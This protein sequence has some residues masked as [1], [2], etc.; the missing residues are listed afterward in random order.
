MSELI[1][2]MTLVRPIR[3][4][5]V[6]EN[7]D[8]STFQKLV[9]F[10][11]EDLNGIRTLIL[12]N[13]EHLFSENT[14]A[15]V[16]THDPDVILNY[17]KASDQALYERYRTKVVRTNHRPRELQPYRTHLATVQQ[18]PTV[19]RNIFAYQGKNLALDETIYALVRSSGEKED[20]KDASLSPTVEELCFAVNCGSV[21]SGFFDMRKFGVFRDVK[22]ES[23]STFR[24][25]V[26]AVRNDDRFIQLSTH[27]AGNGTSQSIWEVDHNFHQS[28]QDKSTIIIGAGDDLRSL[29]YFW[30]E[31]ASYE[32]SR[33]VWLPAERADSY[34]DLLGDFDHYCLFESA[35]IFEQLETALS[36]KT[37]VDNSIYY[38]P[39]ILFSDSF[40]NLQVIQR[41]RGQISISHPAERLFSRMS[42]YMFEVRGLSE[43]VWPVSAALGEMFLARHSKIAS[44]YFG[45]RIGRSG[46]ATSTGQFSVFEDEDLFVNLVLPDKREMFK[47][48]FQ[49]H[50]LKITETRGTKVI[51]RIINLVGGIENLDVFANRE[52]FELLVKLTPRRAARVVKELLKQSPDDLANANLNELISQNISNLPGLTAPRAV[53]ADELEQHVAGGVKDKPSFYAGVEKLY[54]NK[55]LLRGKCFSCHQCEGELWFALENINAENKCYRCDQP[56]IIPTFR[57]NRALTDSFRINELIVSAVDQGVLPVLLTLYFLTRQRFIAHKYFYNCELAIDFKPEYRGELDIIF[58]IGRMIGLGEI[59]AD[60]GFEVGQV[61]SLIDIAMRIGARVL[62]FS[63]LKSRTSDEVKSLYAHLQNRQISVPA[64]ILSQEVLFVVDESITI[65]KYFEV[66]KDNSLVSGPI[67]V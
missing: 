23:V 37:R 4:L 24:Q 3:K 2:V 6:I 18:Y 29:T 59:K 13:D 20:D 10:C 32:R 15:L 45:S 47:A 63:T 65:S 22:I 56:V 58:T 41:T 11:S 57:N 30:N 38:F 7:G 50:Q 34:S 66:G 35:G 5:F 60:R 9:E 39:E 31:R 51:D 14:V 62:L 43:G 67:I 49:D 36:A 27:F 61:D 19:L 17:S 40:S 16:T 12:L 52:I 28:F 64:L 44:S 1:S 26:D 21:S 54:Q 46:F 8:L 55:V 33:I 42:H 53:A 25:L 48:F